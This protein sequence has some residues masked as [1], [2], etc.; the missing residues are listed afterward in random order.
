M[1]DTESGPSLG[2]RLLAVIVLAVAAWILFKLVIGTV[3]AIAW[4]AAAIAAVIAVI[5]AVRTLT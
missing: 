4:A 1:N 3:I 5:W 2:A